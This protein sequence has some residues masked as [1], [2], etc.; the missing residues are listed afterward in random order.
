MVKIDRHV[1]VTFTSSF[2]QPITSAVELVAIDTSSTFTGSFSG[3]GFSGGL[4][5]PEKIAR[6]RKRHSSLQH[7]PEHLCVSIFCKK[8]MQPAKEDVFLEAS[9]LNECSKK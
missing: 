7:T 9:I 3:E 4:C 1:V 2:T 8:Y 5:V 6:K